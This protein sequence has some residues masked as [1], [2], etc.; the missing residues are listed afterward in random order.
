VPQDVRAD[1]RAGERR[2]TDLALVLA[3]DPRDAAA[4]E[5]CPVLAVEQRV[6][7]VAGLS[8]RFSDR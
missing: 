3:D 2:I 8:S 4:A 1:A 7:V 6:V 5:P